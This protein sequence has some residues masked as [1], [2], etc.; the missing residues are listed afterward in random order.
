[1]CNLYRRPSIVAS[2][3]VSVHLAKK[4]QRRRLKYEQL[5]DDRRRT[6]DDG[7]RAPSDGSSSHCL[8]QGE[9]TTVIGQ[10]CHSIRTHYS[11]SET[12]LCS[13]SLMLRCGEATN[14]NFIFFCLTRPQF[15]PTI[16]RTRGE[17]ANHYAT[18]AVPYF[19]LIFINFFN[20]IFF[21]VLQYII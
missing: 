3:Q 15:V 17:H 1:M 6:K 7:R 14:T 20:Q 19:Y 16:Y 5:M 12:R 10:I 4:F 13:F 9:L 8:W 18:D 2:Y 11:D 21:I